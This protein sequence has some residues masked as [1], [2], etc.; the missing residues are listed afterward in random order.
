MTFLILEEAIPKM[1]PEYCPFFD[2]PANNQ[3]RNKKMIAEDQRTQLK[4]CAPLLPLY[5]VEKISIP[6]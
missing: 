2:E 5:D 6:G 3:N 4:T 1:K